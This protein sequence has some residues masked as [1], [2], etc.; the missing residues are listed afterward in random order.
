VRLLVSV[1]D[2]EEVS[3]SIAGGADIVD[4]KNPAEGSL[5]AATPQNVR[6]IIQEVGLRRETSCAIGDMPFLPG[7]AGLAAAGAAA[8]TPDYVKLGLL[9]ATTTRQASS[10]LAAAVEGAHSVNPRVSVIACG[11]GDWQAAGCVSPLELPEIADS[12]GA[13]GVLVDTLTKDGRSL[14]DFISVKELR[15]FVQ[16]ARR[17][18]LL[19]ALAGSLKPLH[20]GSLTRCDPDIVG[21]RG[22]AC[23]G[24]DRRS[25]IT[26]P[27]RIREFHTLLP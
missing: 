15:G 11:Y 3:P 21:I 18:S 9:G 16:N 4:I 17:L 20:A 25:R 23:D 5:G 12:V 27:D 22:A 24:S 26:A 1:V 7:T 10:L 6:R 8:L 19:S 14:F 2:R 13:A